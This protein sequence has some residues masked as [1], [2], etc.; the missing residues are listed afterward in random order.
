MHSIQML[1]ATFNFVRCLTKN[2]SC[3]YFKRTKCCIAQNLHDLLLQ[4]IEWDLC[5][6][7]SIAM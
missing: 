3:Q 7:T 5:R 6:P 4:W 1:T 2:L